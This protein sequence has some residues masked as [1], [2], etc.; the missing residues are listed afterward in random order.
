MVIYAISDLEGF[1]PSELLPEY[2][3][4]DNVISKEDN[5]VIICGDV[6]DSTMITENDLIKKKKNKNITTIHQLLIRK[7]LKLTF[8]NRDLNKLKVGPLTILKTSDSSTNDLVNKFNEGE[9]KLN[10]ETYKNL[11]AIQS[12]LVWHHKMS[13]WY[14]FWGDEI[15]EKIDYWKNDGDQSPGF[16]ERRFNKIF[17]ADTKIGTMSANNLLIAIPTEI[18]QPATSQELDE[19][20]HNDY[21]AFVVL[22]VFRSMLLKPKPEHSINNDLSTHWSQHSQRGF[23]GF[24]YKMFTDEKNDMIIHKCVCTKHKFF[25]SICECVDATC[26]QC[27]GSKNLYLFSHGGVTKNIIK[28]NTLEEILKVLNDTNTTT[29]A[30]NLTSKLKDAK[31]LSGASDQKLKEAGISKLTGGYYKN[32]TD[33]KLKTDSE[34]KTIDIIKNIKSFNETMKKVI[35]S[36]LDNDVS[37]TTVT[38]PSNNMLLLLI[39]SATFDCSSYQEKINKYEKR[40]RLCENAR[41]LNTKSDILS[42]MAGIIRLRAEHSSIFFRKGKLFNIF[43][44]KPVGFSPTIDLFENSD[45]KTYLINLDTSNTFYTTNANLH[46]EVKKDGYIPL[47]NKKKSYLKIDND[48]VSINSN[49]FITAK[50]EEILINPNPVNYLTVTSSKEQNQ[51]QEEEKEKDKKIIA[52]TTTELPKSLKVPFNFK[53]EFTINDELDKKLKQIGDKNNIYY[54]GVTIDKKILFTINRTGFSKC[55]V[56]L[57]EKEFNE[58]FQNTKKGGKWLNKYLKYKQKYISLKK[59]IEL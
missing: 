40:D 54:H 53:L 36:I 51:K 32:M 35:K 19:S 14:P 38:E 15:I 6:L 18:Q 8:G 22:A 12:K 47:P 7:N 26:S 10:I 11:D 37:D 3:V 13:N 24:L 25:K 2:A 1:E 45:N 58:F 28:Q 17:G 27:E 46:E 48:D 50:E 55:L 20:K 44:H 49:I 21:Y 42:T 16:F 39:A 34:L 5:E 52:F 23:R 31:K 29:N 9:L 4:Y 43:G 30:Y 41:I 59:Q 57:T 56:V 33:S